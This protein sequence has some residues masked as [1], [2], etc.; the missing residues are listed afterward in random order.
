LKTPWQ[1]G[2]DGKKLPVK[3]FICTEI[4]IP[5]KQI[6]QD[7]GGIEVQRNLH[8]RPSSGAKNQIK[9]VYCLYCRDG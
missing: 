8:G 4:N 9:Q 7:I 3:P 1:F 5:R 2:Y 6:Q